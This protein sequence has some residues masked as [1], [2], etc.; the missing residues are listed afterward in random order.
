MDFAP[1]L[2]VIDMVARESALF[3][4]TGFLIGGVDDLC[5]DLLYLTSARRAVEPDGPATARRFAMLVPAWDEAAVIAPMLTAAL[6]RIG[7]HDVR[8][9]VGAYPNDPATIAAVERIAV[10]E[11]RVRLVV[12]DRPGPTTKGDNLNAMWHALGEDEAAGDWRAD[13]IVLHDA[14]DVIDPQEFA[15]FE[16]YLASYDYVQLPVRPLIPADSRWVSAHYG[17]MARNRH[18]RRPRREN[19]PQGY[20]SLARRGKTVGERADLN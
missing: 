3:A 6:A 13:T 11:A 4:A 2:S 20:Q 8:I 1:A 16:R 12:G 17:A 5:A 15:V 10:C 9:Y 18:P 19:R 7:G 14:E